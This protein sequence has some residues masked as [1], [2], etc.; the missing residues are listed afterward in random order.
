MVWLDES[1]LHANSDLGFYRRMGLD[2]GVY[3]GATDTHILMTQDKARENVTHAWYD[4]GTAD[5]H[6]YDRTTKATQKNTGLR[7]RVLVGHGREPTPRRA[8]WKPGRC[9]PRWWPAGATVLI[10]LVDELWLT[11]PPMFVI[12]MAWISVA[13]SPAIAAQVSTDASSAQAL[14]QPMVE[15]PAP[16]AAGHQPQQHRGPDAVR[17]VGARVHLQLDH[18]GHDQQAQRR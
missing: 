14:G 9:A 6:P 4:E 15:R 11:V 16:A 1:P 3:D 8:V 17:G 12:G 10:V 2:S 7:R 18:R 13:N 5:M